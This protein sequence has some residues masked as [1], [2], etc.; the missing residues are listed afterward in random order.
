MHI[1]Y[2]FLRLTPDEAGF[3]TVDDF[4]E[5]ICYPHQAFAAF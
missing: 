5:Q 4:F 2:F 1:L 3:V